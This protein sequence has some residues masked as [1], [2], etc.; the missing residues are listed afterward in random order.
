MKIYVTASDEKTAKELFSKLKVDQV[1][2]SF[3]FPEHWLNIDGGYWLSTRLLSILVIKED[4]EIPGE[5]TIE[6]RTV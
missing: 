6:I 1:M 5:Q 4:V 3:I 2:F